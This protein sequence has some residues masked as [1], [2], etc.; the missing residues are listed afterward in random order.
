MKRIRQAGARIGGGVKD[1]TALALAGLAMPIA[2]IALLVIGAK[3]RERRLAVRVI[4][5]HD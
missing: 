4:P 3:S 1:W 2:G 5:D